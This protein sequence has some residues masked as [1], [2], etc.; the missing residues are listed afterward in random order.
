[1]IWFRPY[2]FVLEGWLP[3]GWTHQKLTQDM[4]ELIDSLEL[5][6]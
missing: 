6:R 4:Q 1:M 3:T 2:P 5:T